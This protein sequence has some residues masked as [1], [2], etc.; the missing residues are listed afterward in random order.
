MKASD[1]MFSVPKYSAAL[2]DVANQYKI[3]VNFKHNLVEIK[4][5][6]IAVF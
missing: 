1:V 5:N 6:N 3:Q 2:K 4:D